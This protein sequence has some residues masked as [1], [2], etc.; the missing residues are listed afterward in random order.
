MVGALLLSVSCGGDDGTADGGGGPTGA[1]EV[2]AEGTGDANDAPLQPMRSGSV[3]LF[4]GAV[5]RPPV[6]LASGRIAYRYITQP[7]TQTGETNVPVPGESYYSVDE[8]GIWFE[9]DTRYGMIG[10]SILLVPH[11]VRVGMRW[12]SGGGET[13]RTYEVTARRE[14]PSTLGLTTFWTIEQ[15]TEPPVYR[16]YAEGWG[17]LAAAVGYEPD[18]PQ[19][20]SSLRA[21]TGTDPEPARST[22]PALTLTPVE[23]VYEGILNQIRVDSVR[24]VRYYDGGVVTIMNIMGTGRGVGRPDGVYTTELA[25]RGM[26]IHIASATTASVLPMGTAVPDQGIGASYW[27]GPGSLFGLGNVRFLDGAPYWTVDETFIFENAIGGL[28]GVH[29]HGYG[30]AP[31]VIDE[32]PLVEPI[33]GY[34]AAASA[35]PIWGSFPHDRSND[36]RR[37]TLFGDGA[38]DDHIP[39]A[40]IY[41]RIGSMWFGSLESLPESRYIRVGDFVEAFPDAYAPRGG[42]SRKAALHTTTADGSQS[43]FLTSPGGIIDRIVV[44]RA[45]ARRERVGRVELPAGHLLQA[46]AESVDG[47]LVVFTYTPDLPRPLT[48]VWRTEAGGAEP[49]APA[50]FVSLEWSHWDLRVCWPATAERLDGTGWRLGPAPAAAV[51]SVADNCALVVRDLEAT[52][53]RASFESPDGWQVFE[54]DVPGVGHLRASEHGVGNGGTVAPTGGTWLAAGG[55]IGNGVYF[56]PGGVLRGE[57][58]FGGGALVDQAGAGMW[59]GTSLMDFPDGHC[60]PSTCVPDTLLGFVLSGPAPLFFPVLDGLPPPP[61]PVRGGGVIVSGIRVGSD[62]YENPV[63]LRADGTATPLSL[64]SVYES[65]SFMLIRASGEVCGLGTK[66]AGGEFVFCAAADGSALREAAATMGPQPTA[67]N[68]WQMFDDA[69]AFV[70]APGAAGGDTLWLLDLDA[71]ESREYPGS[72]SL[73]AISGFSLGADGIIYGS[74]NSIPGAFRAA[75]FIPLSDIYDV[76]ALFQPGIADGELTWFTVGPDVVTI[77]HGFHTLRVPRARWDAD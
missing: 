41:D 63:H 42:Y 16:L 68:G 40:L 71:L 59:G 20:Y 17:V 74:A 54:G 58:P 56:A 70:V 62:E 55:V 67:G 10:D 22:G 18:I 69:T 8:R 51:V 1:F 72:I 24:A 43:H 19:I 75:G 52:P 21:V 27:Y 33:H 37:R 3:L 13:A 50:P 65:G 53:I 12:R 38:D 29:L 44:D 15:Q 66:A 4:N 46:V 61:A 23:G 34:G 25:E 77:T 11:E 6:A 5:V 49:V 47:G 64:P 9:G 39:F 32:L 45:G 14:Q 73:R 60:D 76:D 2:L 7:N 57:P 28:G 26:A 48:Q 30:G 35:R 36:G 31:Q